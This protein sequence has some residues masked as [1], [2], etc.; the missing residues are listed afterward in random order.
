MPHFIIDCSESIF[1]RMKGDPVGALNDI[2]KSIALDPKN[3]EAYCNLGLVHLSKGNT[4]EG[5]SYLDKC[6]SRNPELRSRFEK[7]AREI[8]R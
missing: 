1:L 4:A 3:A 5:N 8:K 7:L 6:Y 2:T